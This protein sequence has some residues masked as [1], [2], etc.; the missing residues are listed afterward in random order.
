[1]VSLGVVHGDVKG[2]LCNKIRM[3]WV[4]VSTEHSRQGYSGPGDAGM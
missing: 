1:M 2:S 4:D 3:V